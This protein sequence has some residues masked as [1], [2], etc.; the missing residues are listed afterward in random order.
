MF[1]RYIPCM[2]PSLSTTGE[3]LSPPS[4]MIAPPK[5]M[6]WPLT[7]TSP[8]RVQDLSVVSDVYEAIDGTFRTESPA[9]TTSELCTSQSC[10][11]VKHIQLHPELHLQLQIHL[12]HHFRP[13]P[14]APRRLA[15]VPTPPYSRTFRGRSALPICAAWR[16]WYAGVT[17]SIGSVSPVSCGQPKC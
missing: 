3:L 11:E 13:H 16:S 7:K 8:P 14:S 10:T 5:R 12:Q 4:K 6:A 1:G 15:P 2:T 17:I 9:S